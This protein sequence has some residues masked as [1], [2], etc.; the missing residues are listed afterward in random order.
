MRFLDGTKKSRRSLDGVNNIG[1]MFASGVNGRRGADG[2]NIKEGRGGYARKTLD[3]VDLTR[4]GADG[5]ARWLGESEI[6]PESRAEM[7]TRRFANFVDGGIIAPLE[8][9]LTAREQIVRGAGMSRRWQPY[10][11]E[12]AWTLINTR[13]TVAR[14]RN[15]G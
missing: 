9:L 5:V 8:A 1:D 10:E 13:N 15:A 11:V 2:K 7:W 4:L 3:S 6:K 14:K 12:G